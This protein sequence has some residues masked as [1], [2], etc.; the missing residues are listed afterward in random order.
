MND[1]IF[2]SHNLPT[3]TLSSVL[4]FNFMLKFCVKILFCKHCFSPLNTFMRKGKDPNPYLWLMDPDREGPKTCRSSGSQ[5]LHLGY[6]LHN[7]P[8]Y[9][10]RM[11]GSTLS[12]RSRPPPRRR[13]Q[14]R[15]GAWRSRAPRRRP[16]RRSRRWPPS[17]TSTRP[18]RSTGSRSS[19]GSSAARTF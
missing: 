11:L 9:C 12:R 13:R 14:G 2:F 16:S 15:A 19:S 7:L 4:K 6:I 10:R 8:L 3:G 5:T 18:G 1:F 17:A